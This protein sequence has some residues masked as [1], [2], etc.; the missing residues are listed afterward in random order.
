MGEA[1][2]TWLT[3][4]PPPPH[5][6]GALSNFIIHGDAHRFVSTC[7]FI[8]DRHR[9]STSCGVKGKNPRCLWPFSFETLHSTTARCIFLT[10][11]ESVCALKRAGYY[12]VCQ[13][14]A[15]VRGSGKG[16]MPSVLKGTGQDCVGCF[17]G[18][19]IFDSMQYLFSVCLCLHLCI[20]YVST[21]LKETGC[22]KDLSVIAESSCFYGSEGW[23]AFRP[24]HHTCTT[25]PD[26]FSSDPLGW[27]LSDLIA[28]KL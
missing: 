11:C 23:I 28:L 24:K 12:T 26:L 10:V 4:L 21:F 5:T 3:C 25:H 1:T 15:C 18:I 13:F 2:Q 7:Q 20:Q 22:Y 8:C 6:T 9:R 17:F 16:G 19:K 14:T 27:C